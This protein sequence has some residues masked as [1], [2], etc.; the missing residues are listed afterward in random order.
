MIVYAQQNDTVDALCWR[1]LGDTLDV[2]EQTY[3]L[4]P[5]L[6]DQGP[7][8]QHGTAVVLPDAVRRTSTVKTVKLWD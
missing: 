7:I 8:L 4:N 3:E 1:H 5:R 2:V 6:A